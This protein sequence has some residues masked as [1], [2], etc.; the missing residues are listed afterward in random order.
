MKRI[1]LVKTGGFKAGE[2]LVTAEVPIPTDLQP[3]YVLIAVEASAVNPIDWKQ[4]IMGFFMPPN[5]F[6]V[7]LG[8][9]VAGVVTA[10]APD[11]TEWLGMRLYSS[12][13]VVAREADLTSLWMLLSDC[14][15]REAGRNIS[16]LRQNS[17]T[18]HQRRLCRASRDGFE[19]GCFRT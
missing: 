19:I 1:D 18:H 9:D 11:A 2:N 3:G 15:C 13:G 5:E 8:C 14:S 6:P 12:C 4:A 16:W 10:T 17:E 7:A